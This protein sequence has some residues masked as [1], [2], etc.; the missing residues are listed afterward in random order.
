M[1]I[2][3]PHDHVE[4]DGEKLQPL[5]P[6]ELLKTTDIKVGPYVVTAFQGM[7]VVFE[8]L[9]SLPR[10]AVD[11]MKRRLSHDKLPLRLPE[12]SRFSAFRSGLFSR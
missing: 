6:P 4:H 1:E 3:G 12:K 2:D 8:V 7:K 9:V 10:S 11:D 5:L